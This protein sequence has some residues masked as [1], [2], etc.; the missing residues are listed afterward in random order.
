M[1]SAAVTRML[2]LGVVS[3]FQPVNGYQVMRELNSWYVEDWAQVRPGSI[4]S[5]L[6]SLSKQGL[7]RRHELTEAD[8][9]V[10]V[11]EVD[12]A[13]ADQLN[14]LVRSGLEGTTGPDQIMFQAAMSFA[15][16]LTR[17]EVVAAIRVRV[18]SVAQYRDG[19]V[20]KISNENI[21]THVRHTLTMHYTL[22][23]AELAWT[24]EFATMLDNGFLWFAGESGD[25]W[26][27][28]E[29]DAGWEMVEQARRYR[30]EIAKRYG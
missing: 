2:V 1:A 30:E 15:P 11:Y 6:N 19:L 3:L 12:P 20:A 14:E 25:P 21:P 18:D 9:A 27:P 4:Y 23:E 8:R 10:A 29:D 26:K 22:A 16:M 13:G 17:A 24:R 5:M 28:P 7:L